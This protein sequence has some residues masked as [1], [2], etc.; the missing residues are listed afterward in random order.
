MPGICL[1]ELPDPEEEPQQLPVVVV[2]P[3]SVD[4]DTCLAFLANVA[5]SE[6]A[7]R[8]AVLDYRASLDH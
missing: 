4:I 5:N 7:A 8:T 6:G 3:G 2:C 1:A